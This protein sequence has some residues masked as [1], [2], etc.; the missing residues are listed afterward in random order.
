MILDIVY[1]VLG[2]ALILVGANALTDGASA[3]ARR[4]GISD[5]VVGLTVVAFGTST[6]EL[7]ISLLS[8]IN[9]NPGMAVGNVVGSNIFNILAIVGIT[10]IVRPI[11]IE[12]TVMTR[13]IP[14]MIISSLVLLILGNTVLLDGDGTAVASRA[15]GLILLIFFGI[16]MW[17]TFASAKNAGPDEPL[18][19][20]NASKK[21][22][23][24]TKA[25]LWVI[26]GLAMLVIGGDRF[27]SGASGI[28]S[29]MGISD[30]VIGLTIAAA[31]SSLPELATSIVAARKG[32]TSMAVGN[33]IGSNIFNIFFVLGATATVHPVAF[34][35]IGNVDL[36]TLMG[37]SLLFLTCGWLFG[38]RTITRAEGAVFA[39]CYISYISYLVV[40][41]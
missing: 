28:A 32:R 11:V 16:F 30:A 35:G 19:S 5:L 8:A 33:V 25:I 14:M 21:E 23:K 18:A 20:D 24:L 37:A 4:M 31:G 36:L 41:A 9:G 6:P 26:G 34:G 3:I 7:V 40:T 2:L 17:Y 10:A 29:M 27:V 1:I 39:L 13:E 38:K 15:E 22:F 12:R